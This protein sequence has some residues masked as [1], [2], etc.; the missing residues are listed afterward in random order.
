MTSA[1]DLSGYALER[2]QING[3]FVLERGRRLGTNS[4]ILVLRPEHMHSEEAINQRLEHEYLLRSELDPAWAACPL[5]L[6]RHNGRNVLVLTDPGGMPL[7]RMLTK[8]LEIG[9]FLRVAIGLAAALRCVHAR[10]LIHRDINPANVL[11]DEQ[12]KVS[13]TGFGLATQ[14]PDER[15]ARSPPQV[16]RGTWA[17]MAP[18]QTGRVNRFV[19]SRSDLY[20]LGVTFYEMLTGALPFTASDPLE[21]IHCHVARQPP[22]PRTRLRDVPEQLEAIV[23][24][25]L[26]KTGEDRYQSA[27]GV[28]D[29]LQ[30][31]LNSWAARRTIDPFAVAAKEMS[32]GLH[33]PEGLYGRDRHITSVLAAFDR[34]ASKGHTEIV[35]VSGTAGVGKSS[36]VKELEKALVSTHSLFAA[37]KADQYK[38]DIPYP[39]MAQAFRGLVR[40]ILSLESSD[41]DRWRRQL[42]EALGPNGQLMINLIPE[43]MV[44]I[45]QQP[46]PPELP[47]Q[48]A[49]SRFH[50]VF[51]RLLSVFAQPAHPLTLFIDDLQWLDTAT[52]DLIERLVA[53]PD[54][55]HLLLIGAYRD[56]E[57]RPNDRLALT[58]PAM[59]NAKLRLLEIQ[60]GPLTR[61]DVERMIA[62]TLRTDPG[63]VKSLA[64]VVFRK[65]K[66][67]PFFA[68]QFLTNLHD[69]RM[70]SF[71]IDSQ[72]WRWDLRR[73]TGQSI[74]DNVA[75][76]LA[77]KLT[78]LS[79][80]ALAA[81]KTLACLGNGAR[82]STLS[83][84]IGRSAQETSAALGK[85]LR[86]G[87]LLQ[88]D[89][90]YVFSHD[91][92]QEAA[93]LLIAESSRAATHLQIGR[94]LVLKMTATDIQDHIFEIVE[95]FTRAA[96]LIES[97]AERE[98]VA[99]LHFQAGKR[100]KT[101]TAYVSALKYFN[102]GRSLLQ[103]YDW[104]NQYDLTFGLELQQAEC[105]FLTGD[106][107]AAEERLS[108]LEIRA[109]N[110]IHGAA[111][112]RLRI[113]LNTLGNPSRAVQ[114]GLAFLSGIGIDWSAHP[115][116]SALHAEIDAMTHLLAA[117]P[118][119]QLVGLPR[120]KD[121]EWLAAMDVFA[122]LILPAKITDNNLEN[123]V[124]VRMANISLQHGN[125]DA[126]CY[127][128]SQLNV[129]LGLRFGNYR[130]GIRF[131][132][133]G[134]DLVDEHGMDR[135]KAR[136][137][138]CFSTYGLPWTCH[139][140]AC[141]DLIRRSVTVADAAGDLVFVSA[142]AR[143]V[144]GNLLICGEPLMEVRHEAEQYLTLA[145][146]AGFD[147]AADGAISM[148][149]LIYDLEGREQEGTLPEI[150]NF[151]R[152]SFERYLQEGG[153]AASLSFAFYWL[154]RLQAAYVAGNGPLALQ[155]VAKAGGAITTHRWMLDL[156]EYHF[157]GA[158]VRAA[159]CDF[160]PP[161]ERSH[162][163]ERLKEHQRQNQI[164][165]D[166]CP[167]NFGCRAALIAAEVARLDN[168]PADAPSLYR[169]A[170]RLAREYGFVQNEALANELAAQFHAADGSQDAADAHLQEALSCYSRWGAHAKVR[171]L[172]QRFPHL[173]SE[174]PN[175][176]RTASVTDHIQ[177]LDMAAVIEMSQAVSSEVVFDRLVERLMLT[178]VEHAGAARGLMLLP[179]DGEMRVAAEAVARQGN[180]SVNLRYMQSAARELPESILNYVM[181]SHEFVIID[182]AMS[183][184]AY[185]EDAYIVQTRPRSI[186]CMPLL[187]QKR[188]V[189]ILYIENDLLPGVFTSNK[190]LV[191][192][193]LGSQ[194]AI[195]IEN[196][197]LF[198]DLSEAQEK[199]RRA[200]EQTQQLFDMIPALA[201]RVTPS[202]VVDAINK[203]WIDYTGISWDEAARGEWVRA[204]PGVDGQT[205]LNQ[206]AQ[207]FTKG[208]AGTVETWLRRHD[209][210]LR[211]F[212]H[213][214][215]PHYDARGE[216][217]HW[218][219]TA[220]DIDDLK[221]AEALIVSEK[222][223]LQM[224]TE[225]HTMNEILEVLVGS[226]EKQ[227]DGSCAALLL[228]QRTTRSL[229]HIAAPSLPPSFKERLHQVQS[230]PTDTA[231]A[232]G[233][234]A[235]SG[236]NVHVSDI[237]TDRGW[238]GL[239][240]DALKSG[241]KM[242]WST[243]VVSADG[244][245]LGVLAVY[246]HTVREITHRE[247]SVCEQFAHLA[248]IILDRKHAED[249]L[250]RSEAMLAEGQR[251]SHTG[252]WEWTRATDR[253]SLSA[254]CARLMGLSP[255]ETDIPYQ[256][257]LDRIHPEDRDRVAA[258]H[259]ESAHSPGGFD[260]G[261]RIQLPDGS[262]RFVETRGRLIPGE[263]GDSTEYVGTMVDITD[264]L[265]SQSQMRK[266][267]S[268]IDNSRDSI[269]YA[270]LPDEIEYLNPAW[271]ALCGVAP[272]EDLARFKLQDF[273][274]PEDSRKYAEEIIPS[275]S[276]DGFWEG[277][278]SL[279]NART[280][281]ITPVQQTIFYVTD[282]VTGQQNSIA[283]I[284][285]DI[286]EQKKMNQR[287]QESLSE[288]ES[289]L[290]EVHHRVKNNLQLIS[291]MLN[292]QAS[293]I[294]DPSVAELFAES[295]NRVRSMALVHENLYRAGNFSKISMED[296]IQMLSGSLIR[297][298]GMGNPNVELETNVEDIL[299]G[300]E[301]AI[302]VGLIVNELTSN[303]LKHAFPDGRSGTVGVRLARGGPDGYILTVTDDGVGLP[304][305]VDPDDSPS[306]GLQL[307]RDLAEQ[308]HGVVAVS[309]GRGTTFTV[310][311][312]S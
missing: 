224:N 183:G 22:P 226:V 227:I 17:Y 293:R 214:V 152:S 37:G 48:E 260:S 122:S 141:R 287:L 7:G 31:C 277:V 13:L 120:M 168:R 80:D 253:I 159:A 162:H 5:A 118:I 269:A 15:K 42:L 35:L 8:P 96:V 89:G 94:A 116:E 74:T 234:A 68:I 115:G 73:I 92:M 146:K 248:S 56:D 195:S 117:R 302:S 60:V 40:R 211:W 281:A 158:L 192:Q 45:G 61:G 2:L 174:V 198:A 151:D 179:Q 38:L 270:R 299:L 99:E 29:D 169:Q 243:R 59:R 160:A 142:A 250:T 193:I 77:D 304:S 306:M 173:M 279:R 52:I 255:E 18:E 62:D 273:R 16:I 210:K 81:V 134:C 311:F 121:P 221:R 161:E 63:A 105:E 208:I 247:I 259:R 187:K 143:A 85:A 249:A 176:A 212:L 36:L 165:A 30:R 236:Q 237:A 244:T 172:Y 185:S 202:G 26:A 12:L 127:A 223:L 305:V 112:A 282:A 204:Y 144:V 79:A 216:I 84:V 6:K 69:E 298:Y 102:E 252:S 157:Y 283:T 57:I 284:C 138:C 114:I 264:R 113:A 23:L 175:R 230:I 292:L 82:L 275:L 229:Y 111:V 154:D 46:P 182:D 163:L 215:V 265:H 43:L 245:P 103:P 235:E 93:Y 191:L 119:E 228:C 266:L 254:E 135:F 14:N 257:F 164:W 239:R 9:H 19:D 136:V 55:R 222:N 170:V 67:N 28:E 241:L 65:T 104:H 70:L 180:V 110:T 153:G 246:S 285:R 124:I 209:G 41:L 98:Q 274:T 186:L 47:P 166:N 197:K 24:K 303:A 309:R 54:V 184:N 44:I 108:E 307:V 76:L 177:H 129:V 139:L 97:Y 217:I 75:E 32:E 83:L 10:D 297:A 39:T 100:A 126:S 90:G 34:V 4:S 21:W 213:R 133:L 11:V 276:R 301:T 125:C 33:I 231:W 155:A 150:A 300:L 51:R 286:T 194:A 256:S 258:M 132:Q 218:H 207:I 58:L 288:K 219:G 178:V 251:I 3:E 220:T 49:Q 205:A 271:R 130:D 64:R 188:L 189:G 310:S 148:L 203:Q 289:L 263:H 66:G 78:R 232:W 107:A 137:Y 206:Y 272:D 233:A 91:R 140:P 201:W 1:F 296:H 145:R 312:H 95:Q 225:V 238:A 156:A 268:L 261:H 294:A 106:Q 149:L 262:V 240:D 86:A 291:S 109:R 308:L 190:L 278:L 196:A 280:G 290:K 267:V 87:F 53:D 200:E 181:R 128:Y 27:G 147:A 20:S 50:L 171:Q 25:L 88:V 71:D 167:D 72:A 295:R 242:C 199:A 131:G 101:S 123:I